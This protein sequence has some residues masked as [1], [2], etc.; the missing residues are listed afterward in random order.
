MIKVKRIEFF[1]RLLLGGVGIFAAKYSLH[2]ETVSV[3]DIY[4]DS[5][6]IAGFQYYEGQNQLKNLKENLPVTLKRQ[7]ENKHDFFAVEVYFGNHKLGYLPR[8][9][10]RIIARMMDQGL[11]LKATIRKIN[12]DADPF[13]K[14]KIRVYSE[15]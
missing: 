2:A 12:P 14:V 7:S 8:S 6:Y 4:L 9:D 11:K 10:N 5:L 15:M 13:W 3:R 1:K